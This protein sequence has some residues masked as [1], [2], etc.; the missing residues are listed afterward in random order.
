MSSRVS[1]A[2]PPAFTLPTTLPCPATS[3]A[4]VTVAL[5]APT[6]TPSYYDI[7]TDFPNCTGATVSSGL[8]VPIFVLTRDRVLALQRSLETYWQ[9]LP[10]GS[11]EIIILDHNSTYPPMLDYLRVLQTQH[12]ITVHTLT[13][14]VW[15][16]ALAQA[17][18]LMQDYLQEHP[19]VEYYVLTDPDI[20]LVRTAPDILLYFAAILTACPD[21]QVVGPHL[22]I[23]DLPR[24]F[25]KLYQ[26]NYSAYEWESQ[27]WK[28]VPHM[29]TWRGVGFH[30]ADQLI[31]TTFALRR[32]ATRFGRITCPCLRTYAPY[33]AVHLDW[34]L[35]SS[36]L[37]PDKQWYLSRSWGG[38]N[39][40]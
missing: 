8:Y 24:R 27:Y 15:D 5:P 26:N 12:S 14:L 18:N 40:W 34:Y 33:T 20:A 7:S 11:Y 13:A 30:I 3:D 23:S 31:D 17:D 19:D 29:A 6:T 36:A 9:T 2:A 35:N 37:P 10:S 38:V 22:Q 1:L 25:T 39:N 28:V 32:R 4:A 21:V 16:D